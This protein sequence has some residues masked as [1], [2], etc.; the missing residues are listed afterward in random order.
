MTFLEL[1]LLRVGH[2]LEAATTALSNVRAR[3]IDAKCRGVFD[4]DALG[5]CVG[6]LD[7]FDANVEL[8]TRQTGIDEDHTA[9]VL[10]NGLATQRKI[11][12]SNA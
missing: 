1:A 5:L 10:G 7:P 9:F 6:L 3:C 4:A 8:I 2:I 12:D 11:F